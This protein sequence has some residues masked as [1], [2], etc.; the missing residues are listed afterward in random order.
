MEENKENVKPYP[1]QENGAN[2]GSMRTLGGS[3]RDQANKME[4]PPCR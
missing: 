1:A 4:T 3:I 2:R